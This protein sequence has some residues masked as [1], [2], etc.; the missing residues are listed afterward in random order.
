[1]LCIEFIAKSLWSFQEIGTMW[2]CQNVYY[3]PTGVRK[4]DYFVHQRGTNP[5]G[6]GTSTVADPGFPRGGY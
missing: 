6:R 2:G 4:Q 5:S 3:I 1:M